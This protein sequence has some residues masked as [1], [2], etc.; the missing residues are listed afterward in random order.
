M[1]DLEGRPDGANVDAEGN[2]WIAGVGGGLLHVFAPDG[3]HIAQHETL[4]LAPTKPAFGGPD[5]DIIFLTSK[6]GDAAG[7]VLAMSH[8]PKGR[9]EPRFVTA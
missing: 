5:L 7:G 6:L 3:K 8:G 1:R 9:P 4:C 2:Y